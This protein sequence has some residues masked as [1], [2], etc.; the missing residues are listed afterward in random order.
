MAAKTAPRYRR[1]R[2][3]AA[4]YR[5][6]RR[7]LHTPSSVQSR[8]GLDWMNFFIAD[9]QTG[10]GSFVAFYL[11]QLGWS[12]ASI[13]AALAAGTITG[14]L[15]QI[16]GGA[17]TD[18]LRWKRALAAAG[19]LMI[20][21]AA[22]ILALAPS[23]V[24]VFL[25][26][27]LHGMTAGVITPAIAAISLG[28]V[29]R[30]AMSVRAGRNYRYA[31]AGNAATAAVMGLAGAFLAPSAIF[32]AAAILCVPA[33]VALGRIRADEID[34][35]RA[36]N[37]NTKEAANVARVFDLAKN[38]KLML[39][40]AALVLFQLADASILPLVGEDLARAVH[41]RASIW[42]SGLIIVPQIIV[43]V[44]APWVGYHS[45]RKGRRPLLLI[46]FAV[47]PIRAALLALTADYPFLVAA[48]VLDGISGAI[49]TVLTLIIITDL[50]TGSGR[51]NLAFGAVG[52]MLGIAASIS[53]SFT[54]LISQHFGHATAFVLIG[55]IA[56]AAV[57]MSWLFLAETRPAQYAD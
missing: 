49:I 2:R 44:F 28:L 56:A 41:D 20:G 24:T 37:A 23:F 42:M 3:A 57:L 18:A 29:G 55:A 19:I 22:L 34:Y 32:L 53:T 30:R 45:E 38:R 6:A 7:A 35:A 33:L 40:V 50:T 5:D 43:A 51:F 46:G 16:P 25:A 15:S 12:Q 26:E 1:L 13:G 4:K 31:A 17:L 39:F 11:A 36:R 10:F 27:I 14:V 21:T 8:R 54:G 48:Q 52:A 9:V 47:E